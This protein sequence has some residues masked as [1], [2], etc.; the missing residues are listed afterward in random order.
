MNRSF[1]FIL[2]LFETYE[3]I[4]IIDAKTKEEAFDLIKGDAAY[5]AGRIEFE[6]IPW[7]TQAGTI[8]R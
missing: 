8:I 2:V 3:D 7:F 4:F 5:V 6:I 1:F